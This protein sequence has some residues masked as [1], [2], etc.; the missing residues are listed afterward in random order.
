MGACA[1]STSDG[2]RFVFAPRPRAT[3]RDSQLDNSQPVGHASESEVPV[4]ELYP[5]HGV[6]EAVELT[7]PGAGG[8]ERRRRP[9]RPRG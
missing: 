3:A 8:H 7:R 1:H 5:G 2:D 4:E 6:D 9:G